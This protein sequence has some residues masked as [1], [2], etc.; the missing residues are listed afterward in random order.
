M[1]CLSIGQVHPDHSCAL[2]RLGTGAGTAPARSLW[3][4]RTAVTAKNGVHRASPDHFCADPLLP[5]ADVPI[6]SQPELRA[7]RAQRR[8]PRGAA[9]KWSGCRPRLGATSPSR[10]KNSPDLPRWAACRW[11]RA[12][13]RSVWRRVRRL[14]LQADLAQQLLQPG[15]QCHCRDPTLGAGLELELQ[16][17]GI[18]KLH[19]SLEVPFHQGHGQ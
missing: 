19:L 12:Q 17:A 13:K 3:Q 11:H 7:W 9:Q 4:T 6:S 2:R 14:D 1:T 15:V 5:C 16:H 18:E 10:H 8:L